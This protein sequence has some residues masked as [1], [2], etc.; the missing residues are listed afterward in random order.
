MPIDERRCVPC[1]SSLLPPAPPAP[2]S[3]RI[4]ES[5]E[6]LRAPTPRSPTEPLHPLWLVAFSRQRCPNCAIAPTVATPTHESE[7]V[8]HEKGE[9]HD[10]RV[11]EARDVRPS[12]FIALV[13]PFCLVPLGLPASGLRASRAARMSKCASASS[14]TR[15]I[16]SLPARTA[17]SSG[18]QYGLHR[19]R[20][21]AD[22]ANVQRRVV[23]YR[24]AVGVGARQHEALNG[25]R[26]STAGCGASTACGGE[27]RVQ[28]SVVVV[29]RD[30][31]V[32]WHSHAAKDMMEK[33]SLIHI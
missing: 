2:T 19:V 7:V 30:A 26:V 14:S 1:S 16:S 33:L 5:T 32:R 24:A 15:T 29:A 10:E 20:V 21:A 11:V 27:L 18:P 9:R 3:G 6:P 17:A 8:A 23:V 4:R 28:G 12:S 22:A 25:A 13:F 31:G